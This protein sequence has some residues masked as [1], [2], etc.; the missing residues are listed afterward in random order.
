MVDW[1]RYAMSQKWKYPEHAGELNEN[2]Q[3]YCALCGT[4]DPFNHNE[5]AH[6]EY[7]EWIREWRKAVR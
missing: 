7:E 6:R 1:K 4:L 2:G 3:Y 5:N